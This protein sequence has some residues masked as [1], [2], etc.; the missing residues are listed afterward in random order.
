ML[1]SD[2]LR[3]RLRA[4]FVFAAA[5]GLSGC[6]APM[7][8]PLAEGG[9]ITGELQAIAVDPIA[10]RIGHYL[11]DD[12]I[13]AFNGTGSS[14]TPRYRLKV[15]LRETVQTPLI[16]T[17]SGRPSAAN[18]LVNA[19]YVLT[20]SGTTTE[21]VKG[22]AVVVASYD[23]TSQRF[24]NVRAARDAEIR[25]AE[26]LAEQIRDRIAIALSNRRGAS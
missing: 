20:Q 3:A 17:V 14:V 12:L 1:S 23:R 4:A 24:A 9:D 8:G 18:V 13:F 7:Y 15:A 5:L 22:T 11:G 6:L 16:D 2:A 26:S 19:D 10:N 25:D 21:I